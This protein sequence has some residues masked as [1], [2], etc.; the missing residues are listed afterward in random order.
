M[1]SCLFCVVVEKLIFMRVIFKMSRMKGKCVCVC[2]TLCFFSFGLLSNGMFLHFKR[3]VLF[4]CSE[5]CW[6]CNATVCSGHTEKIVKIKPNCMLFPQ[7]A[8]K[9]ALGLLLFAW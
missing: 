4:R 9:F 5:I 7:L 6:P 1:R 2:S 8:S 3:K